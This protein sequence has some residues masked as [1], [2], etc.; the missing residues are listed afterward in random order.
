MNLFFLGDIH[1]VY[2]LTHPCVILLNT[3]IRKNTAELLGHSPWCLVNV[4]LSQK[5]MPLSTYRASRPK[6]PLI[7]ESHEL[8]DTLDWHT[9]PSILVF[10][11]WL[12]SCSRLHLSILANAPRNKA[13][14]FLPT[15]TLDVRTT[16][17]GSF[18]LICHQFTERICTIVWS[19]I[20]YIMQTMHYYMC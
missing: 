4:C 8:A 16:P 12:F 18:H 5:H 14:L 3:Y 6:F 2:C 19:T 7:G 13:P 9:I 15:R 11:P 10:W 1:I 20:E 17:G